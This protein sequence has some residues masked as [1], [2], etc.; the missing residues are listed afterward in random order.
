[1]KLKIKNISTTSFFVLAKKFANKTLLFIVVFFDFNVDFIA[2]NDKFFDS[3]TNSEMFINVT[4]VTKISLN[5]KDKFIIN[6]II[7]RRKC[8]LLNKRFEAIQEKKQIKEKKK[9]KLLVLKNY[10]L[11]YIVAFD[12]NIFFK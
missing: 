10:I 9:N 8:Y 7:S 2:S 4:I 1:M 12:N 3:N 5:K 6:K 11:V